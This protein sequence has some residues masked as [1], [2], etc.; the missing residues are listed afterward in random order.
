[1]KHLGKDGVLLVIVKELGFLTLLLTRD[2]FR[3]WEWNIL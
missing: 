1:M 3:V 2:V